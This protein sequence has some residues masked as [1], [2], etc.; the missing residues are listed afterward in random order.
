MEVVVK[1]N[2]QEESDA[3]GDGFLTSTVKI[4]SRDSS[5]EVLSH[6]L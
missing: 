2:F 5:V 3:I 1:L 6:D 4:C